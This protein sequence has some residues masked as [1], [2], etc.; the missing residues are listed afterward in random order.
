M[1]FAED[2]RVAARAKMTGKWATLALVTFIVSLILGVCTSSYSTI[3][4]G[5]FTT[6]CFTSL[7]TIAALVLNGPFELSQNKIALNVMRGKDVTI[8]MTFDGFKNFVNAFLLELVNSIFI[9][10]WSLLFVIP[11]I[12]KELSYSMSFYLLA[13]NPGLTQDQAREK[14]IA[15]MNGNKWRLF[16]LRISFIGWYLLCVI[17]CGIL[18]F[19]VIPYVKCAEAEFYRDLIKEQD[20]MPENGNFNAGSAENAGGFNAENAS[21]NENSAES[22]NNQVPE[23]PFEELK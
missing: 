20:V 13:D 9:F 12:I 22:A 8:E 10:L 5:S 6:V 17:T 18:L 16:C 15:M 23:E 1:K 4:S 21:G 14:S 11:G 2:F 7:G 3:S 19:W